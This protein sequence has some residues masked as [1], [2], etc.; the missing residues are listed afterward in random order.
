MIDLRA[1]AFVRKLCGYGAFSAEELEILNGACANVR[2]VSARQDLAQEGDRPETVFLMLEG[3]A[4]RYTVM[5][6]GGRQVLAFLMPG[7]FCNFHVTLLAEMDHS[8]SAIT[9]G[10]V[11]AI[12]R[13]QVTRLCESTVNLQR[14]FW[15]SQLVDEGVLRSWISSLGRRNSHER[16]AHLMCELYVRAHNVGLTRQDGSCEMPVSQLVLA[17]AL[18]LT[19]VHVNRV[20]RQLRLDNVLTIGRGRLIVNDIEKLVRIAGFQGNYLHRKL[21]HAA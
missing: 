11:A 15:W 17:D 9:P 13:A 4:M 19:P 10:L 21:R 20:F 12:P 1:S 5:P 6:E 3:W 8:I 18:G 14:A 7:D 16:V 2:K